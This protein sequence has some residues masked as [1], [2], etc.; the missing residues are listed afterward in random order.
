MEYSS[1]QYMHLQLILFVTVY[2]DFFG[3]NIFITAYIL[4]CTNCNMCFDM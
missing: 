3:L 1:S 2:I 4:D